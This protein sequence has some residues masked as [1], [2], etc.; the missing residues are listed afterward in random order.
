M[1]GHGTTVIRLK[2]QWRIKICIR[3]KGIGNLVL[4]A[5]TGNEINELSISRSLQGIHEP[6]VA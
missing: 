6:E 1:F 3:V 2:F 5:L 4:R